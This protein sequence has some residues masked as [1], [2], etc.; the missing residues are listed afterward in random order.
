MGEGWAKDGPH[1]LR[2]EK[3]AVG[4]QDH[5]SPVEMDF[6]MPFPCSVPGLFFVELAFGGV[7]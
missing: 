7:G 1:V 5:V 2:P 3:T 6:W 4:M